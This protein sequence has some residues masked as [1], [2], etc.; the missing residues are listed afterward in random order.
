MSLNQILSRESDEIPPWSELTVKSIDT[1]DGIHAQFLRSIEL[2]LNIPTEN[3]ALVY[4]ALTEMLEYKHAAQTDCS[5]IQGVPVSEI[6]PTL[7]QVLAFD[8]TEW[9]PTTSGGSTSL[10]LEGEV[11]MYISPIGDDL[12]DGETPET[13]VLTMERIIELLVNATTLTPVKTAIINFLYDYDIGYDSF[14]SA[15]FSQVQLEE[16]IFRGEKFASTIDLGVDINSNSKIE[17]VCLADSGPNVTRAIKLTY[18]GPTLLPAVGDITLVTLTLSDIEYEMIAY[19]NNASTLEYGVCSYN[20]WQLIPDGTGTVVHNLLP[21][22]NWS[23]DSGTNFAYNNLLR[24]IK[25]EYLSLNDLFFRSSDDVGQQ[26]NDIV[27]TFNCC[28]AE[29]V[30]VDQTTMGKN[31]N[32]TTSYVKCDKTGQV[33]TGA[34]VTFK[35]HFSFDGC[36][37]YTNGEGFGNVDLRSVSSIISN[38]RAKGCNISLDTT[39]LIECNLD[40]CSLETQVCFYGYM[41]CNN[42]TMN[43]ET[44]Y[45]IAN[46]ISQC[47]AG[48]LSNN[49]HC[50]WELRNCVMN[51]PNF[52][53]F[54]SAKPSVSPGFVYFDPTIS[55]FLYLKNTVINMSSSS[56]GNSFY[57]AGNI[58]T[59]N[60]VVM[61]NSTINSND[62]WWYFYNDVAPYGF[63]N[64]AVYMENSKLYMQS[65]GGQ[66]NTTGTVFY[67]YICNDLKTGSV[68]TTNNSGDQL[69]VGAAYS[70]AYINQYDYNDVSLYWYNDPNWLNNTVMD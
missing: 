13:A 39:Y 16:I 42:C 50:G 6:T 47:Y 69:K 29:S 57:D 67:P 28:I 15:D 33:D 38:L 49:L 8:G 65:C 68:D 17:P 2:P 37:A 54:S 60:L 51:T 14:T 53:Y 59:A 31:V 4:N 5:S 30:G 19:I 64:Y 48:A 21:E 34:D 22:I 63:E 32:I 20:T 1:K 7:D 56:G 12:N 27:V 36:I 10:I 25:F 35:Q 44:Y 40:G 61:L 43:I 11:D 70:G 52:M 9:I 62:M 24:S 23:F 66:F 45:P 55:S 3:Q 46:P 26:T 58:C 18:A 41:I